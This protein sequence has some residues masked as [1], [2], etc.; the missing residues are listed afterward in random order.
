MSPVVVP[1]QSEGVSGR[2]RGL[3]DILSLHVGATHTPGVSETPFF[4]PRG[5]YV[6]LRE[7]R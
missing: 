2:G 1:D 7:L 6:L 3:V 4:V 5:G